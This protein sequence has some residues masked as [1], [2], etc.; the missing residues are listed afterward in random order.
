M[1]VSLFPD[2]TNNLYFRHKWSLNDYGP[3]YLPKRGETITLTKENWDWFR[4]AVNRYEQAGITWDGKGFVQGDDKVTTYT[5]KY[6]YY[7]MMGDNRYNSLDS[8]YWGYV[9]EDH[10]VGKP[11][12]T[13]FS[14]KKVIEIDENGLPLI[15]DSNME[16]ET[17]GIRWD[18]IFREIE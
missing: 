13:F 12:F 17:K 11:L 14:L 15:H 10:V 8:R 16:Y 2:T 1:S 5:F 4:L 18:K 3:V 6:G 9:P 7:W